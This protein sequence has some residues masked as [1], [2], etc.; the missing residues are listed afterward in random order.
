MKEKTNKSKNINLNNNSFSM[1]LYI[2]CQRYPFFRKLKILLYF[3]DTIILFLIPKIKFLNN[4]NKKKIFIIYN[5][6]FGDGLIF[7]NVFK[8]IRKIYNRNEYEI[9]LM[10]QKGLEKI[11]EE[12]QVK[13]L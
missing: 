9:T 6:A 5:Y 8:D 1:K 7:L 10:C 2:I 12:Q 11:Y 13:V 3:F 4:S